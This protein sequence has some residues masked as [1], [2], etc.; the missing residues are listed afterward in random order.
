MMHFMRVTLG[1]SRIVISFEYVGP[2]FDGVES[3]LAGT[4]AFLLLMVIDDGLVV[5]RNAAD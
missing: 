3:F 5:G 2:I 4:K 1:N